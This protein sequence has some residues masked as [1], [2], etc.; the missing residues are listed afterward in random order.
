MSTH[1]QSEMANLSTSSDATAE[2]FTVELCTICR[3]LY[4]LKNCFQRSDCLQIAQK[5]CT[6]LMLWTELLER[7]LISKRYQQ[8][9]CVVTFWDTVYSH[10][11]Q[12]IMWLNCHLL[13]SCNAPTVCSFH[14]MSL[15]CSRRTSHPEHLKCQKNCWLA[16]VSD[17]TYINNDCR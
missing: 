6:C 16:I 14:E 7:D 10:S 8:L 4:F 2:K 9:F 1:L 12:C 11:D 13:L 3:F 17:V 5:M 15:K